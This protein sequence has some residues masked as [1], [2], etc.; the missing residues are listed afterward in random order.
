MFGSGVVAYL[1]F[2]LLR[3]F[4]DVTDA[5]YGV[6]LQP[7]IAWALS[8]VSGLVPF[9]VTEVILV[10]YIAV[11]LVVLGRGIL[12]VARR[13]RSAKNAAMALGLVV[14]RDLG[15]ITLGFYIIWGFGYARPALAERL[16]WRDFTAPD[17]TELLALAEQSTRNL[18]AAYLALHHVEDFGEPTVVRDAGELDDAIEIGFRQAV[19]LLGLQPSMGWRYGRAKTPALSTV[20]ARFG[21]AGQYGALTGEPLVVPQPVI[22]RAL[23]IAHEKAHQRGVNQE[24]EARFLSYVT[25]SLAPHPAARYS[26]AFYANNTLLA[27]LPRG[28]RLAFTERRLPGVERDA[29][30]QADWWAPYRASRARAVGTAVNDRFLRANRVEGGIA[31]Y[32]LAVRLLVEFARQNGALDPMGDAS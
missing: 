15:A 4:P 21:V 23:V 28:R 2:R 13:R 19:G 17:S 6:P 30:D 25:A 27:Q 3:V 32:G 29:R 12:F 11:C 9:S 10:G 31:N 1:L 16:S 24:L 20:M 26:A 22:G 18:N 14:L 8:R 7:R 5:L